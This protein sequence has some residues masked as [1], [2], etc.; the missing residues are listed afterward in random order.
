M[1]NMSAPAFS[2][3]SRDNRDHLKKVDTYANARPSYIIIW[4]M[5]LSRATRSFVYGLLLTAITAAAATG[6]SLL[7]FHNL[8]YLAQELP[9]FMALYL[10]LAWFIHLRRT[11]LLHRRGSRDSGELSVGPEESKPRAETFLEN[12]IPVLVWSAAQ[13]AAVATF[14]Y[15]AFSV[16]ATY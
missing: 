3:F 1:I 8:Y 7:H 14:L 11:G 12:P 2:C 15:H 13:L 10:A 6:V 9:I 4:V 5:L 16:G